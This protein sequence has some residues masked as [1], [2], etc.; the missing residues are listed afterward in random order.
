[1][2][3]QEG[4]GREEKSEK[5]ISEVGE[6]KH[7]ELSWECP[8]CHGQKGSCGVLEGLTQHDSRRAVSQHSEGWEEKSV[9][10]AGTFMLCSGKW[11][12]KVDRQG[13]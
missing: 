2:I 5:R 6:D 8:R 10:L 9:S 11:K 1:M 13:E 7:E 3:R 12:L 4:R